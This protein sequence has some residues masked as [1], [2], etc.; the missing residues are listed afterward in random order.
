VTDTTRHRFVR[1]NAIRELGDHGE[2]GAGVLER[3]VDDESLTAEERA[4][5]SVVLRDVRAET[6]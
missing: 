6:D 4:L 1:E 3:I 5:A 2:Q